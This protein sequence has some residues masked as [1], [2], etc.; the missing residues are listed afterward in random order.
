MQKFAHLVKTAEVRGVMAYLVDSEMVKVASAE[1]FDKLVD[2]VSG[3]L[4]EEYDLNTVLSKTAEILDADPVEGN[5]KEVEEP[6]AEGEVKEAQDNYEIE[7]ELG[8]LYMA[9]EAGEI[10]EEYFQKQAG[11]V[12]RGTRHLKNY[13][14]NLRGTRV[15]DAREGV[16]DASRFLRKRPGDVTE[17]GVIDAARALGRE[18]ATRGRTIG[19]TLGAGAAGATGVGGYAAGK[20]KQ[21]DNQ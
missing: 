17:A 19:G 1:D 20:R 2:V 13:A 11:L 7:R 18:Q 10:T 4:G 16:R 5:Q 8:R 14:D 12:R 3:E 21:R 6:A 9:K 15:D